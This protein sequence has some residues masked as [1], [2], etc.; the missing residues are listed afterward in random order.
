MSLYLYGTICLWCDSNVTTLLHTRSLADSPSFSRTAAWHSGHIGS[1]TC[2]HIIYYIMTTIHTHTNMHVCMYTHAYKY[3]HMYVHARTNTQIYS[4][5]PVGGWDTCESP[6]WCVLYY[7]RS[8]LF[9]HWSLTFNTYNYNL[10][11]HLLT[12]RTGKR[13]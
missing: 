5:S 10:P 6:H 13:E 12:F 9:H 7:M 8:K 1:S 11:K 2:Q 3:A 4:H